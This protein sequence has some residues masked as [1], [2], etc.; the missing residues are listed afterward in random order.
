MKY[1]HNYPI[2]HK[3]GK[4]M[5]KILKI[6]GLELSILFY[7][8]VAWLVLVI[9]MIQSGITFLDILQ[10]VRTGLSLGFGTKPITQSL[11]AG[12]GGLFTSMQGYIYLYLPI[13]TM[14][15]MS[16]ETSSGSIK[17]LLSSPVK[18]RQI[19]LGKYLAMITYGLAIIGVLAVFALIGCLFVAH[20]DA[21]LILSGLLGLYLLICTYSA[22]GLFMSCLTTYQVVAAISTMA[23]F[24][25]LRYVGQIGQSIDFVRDLTYFLSISGRAEKMVSGLITTRDIFYYLIIIALFLSLCV[26]KLKGEREIKSWSAKAGRYV[27]LVCIA[28]AMGYITSRPMFT[29]YLDAT[30][31]ESLTITENSQAIAAQIKGPLK[32]TT[33]ANMLAPHLWN[34]LPESRNRD[35]SRLENF[36]RFIPGMDVDYVYYYKSPVDSNY[37]DYKYNPNLRGITDIDQIA[38]KMGSV[39]GI[40]RDLFISAKEIDKQINLEPEGNL[41]VRKLEYNGRSTFLRFFMGSMDPY[42]GEAE[43][44]AALKRLLTTP[45]KII[46]LT[47]N[48]ERSTT[49]P[50]DRDYSQI[51]ALKTRSGALVNQ[52]FDVDTVNINVEGIPSDADVVVIGDPSLPYSLQAQSKIADYISKGGNM[53]ITG[54]PGRQQILNPVLKQLGVQL[55]SGV[56]VNPDQSLTPGLTNA[57]L[58]KQALSVDSNL[59]R[60]QAFK[61]PVGVLGAASVQSLGVSNFTVTPLLLSANGGWNKHLSDQATAEPVP[62]VQDASTMSVNNAPASGVV[63]MVQANRPPNPNGAG[64]APKIGSFDLATAD[65]TYNKANGDQKGTFPISVALTRNINGKQQRIVVSGDADFISNGE[66]PR[67]RSKFNEYY[68][69]G[70]FRWFSNGKFPVDVTRPEARDKDLKIS[71]GQITAL[72]WLC[73]GIIPAFIAIFGAIL[74][75]KRRRN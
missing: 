66:L 62:A 14:S 43:V 36:K 72:M 6:A 2:K 28:L 67:P 53:L 45:S 19:I 12:T 49:K 74:L 70:L 30:A 23:V 50:A 15:L 68:A 59:A 18:L 7:S 46:F 52:G 71:R 73:K 27:A 39:M 42:A 17:L 16:R 10:S 64:D 5:R 60:L 4:Q 26:L 3:A 58:A 40:D 8:P 51:S 29:G 34:V 56:L 41:T 9:F 32:V 25:V 75:F 57:L 44:D 31:Q 65:L 11:F 54:E 22:I 20:A 21:G 47:G 13:L 24:A 33:Y 63:V 61:A 38:D 55:T 69:Q 37:R 35:L 1:L 48:N